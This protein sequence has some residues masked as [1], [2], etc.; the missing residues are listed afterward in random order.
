VSAPGVLYNDSN[1]TGGPL[2]AGLVSGPA[3]GAL[4]LNADGSFTYTPNG[5]YVGTDSFT[6]HASGSSGTSN[7]A[8]VTLSVVNMPPSVSG[9][10]YAVRHD[11]TLTVSAPGVLQGVWDPNGDPLTAV[12]VSGPSHGT[13]TF[14]PNGSFVYTPA[15]HFVG[16][17]TFYFKATDGLADSNIAPVTI[18]V[19]NHAPVARS[20]A[21]TMMQGDTLTVT[22][23]GV[24]GNDDDQDAD[25]LSAVLQSAPAVGTFA[26][27][28]DGSFTFTPPP[29]F[30]GAVEALY[31][32][33]DQIVQ[34]VWAGIKITV[35]RLVATGQ[36]I[37]RNGLEGASGGQT[38][39]R[40]DRVTVGAVTVAN[41]NNT[42]GD[43]LPN[44][45]ENIDV[46]DNDVSIPAPPPAGGVPGRDEIDLI[47]LTLEQPQILGLIPITVGSVRVRVAAGPVLLFRNGPAGHLQ[48]KSNGAAPASF[49]MNAFTADSNGNGTNDVIIWAEASASTALQ[50]IDLRY[51]YQPPGTNTWIQLD[52][53][54]ATA[55]WVTATQ[56]IVARNANPVPNAAGGLPNLTR[57]VVV[58]GI[59]NDRA[60]DGT[61]YGFGSLRSNGAAVGP[62]DLR[63]G[64][65]IVIE[66]QPA[67][68]N[69]TRLGVVFDI[70][71]QVWARAWDIVNG[72]GMPAAPAISRN[73]PW[74]D[75]PIRD[76]ELPNDDTHD[77]DEQNTPVNNFIYVYDAPSNGSRQAANAFDV[78]R[79]TFKEWV[80][81]QLGN[82]RFANQRP[83]PAGVAPAAR[84]QVQG[85]RASDKVDWNMVYYIRRSNAAGDMVQDSDPVSASFPVL[86]LAAGSTANGTAAV[87]FPNPTTA[88]LEGFTATY[89]AATQTWTLLG[90]SG[91][92]VAVAVAGA[93]PAG[94]V[95]TLN[96]GTK[97]TLTITQGANAFQNGDRFIFSTLKSTAVGGKVNQLAAGLFNVGNVP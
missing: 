27:G 94:T 97:L 52:R 32:A 39:P 15:V 11:D 81:V 36:L 89:A 53:V 4:A 6:Y 19:Y 43:F 71:R 1:P 69:A 18:T 66:F 29:D 46:N 83:F 92:T 24:L 13:L 64:G 70:T 74:L 17:D 67:P 26:L 44:G 8:I 79:Y 23:P 40:N 10:A 58:N 55:V 28:A 37:T 63:F 12:L 60:V 88:V 87:T 96:L 22:A 25:P 48:S 61:R 47:R 72:Q 84:Q 76:N 93:I 80:R 62:R 85:S 68:A 50:G 5:G 9:V 31:K 35:F 73:F 91:D 78:S 21:Y 16:T 49:A 57:A 75:T 86:T 45:T 82:T 7:T 42:D 65:R 2:S 14:Q 90:T 54:T 95:W 34:S 77:D 41:L 59:N 30:K 56:T 20:E 51:E 3:H 33:F 38:V